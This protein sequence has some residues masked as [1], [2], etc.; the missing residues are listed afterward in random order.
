M[1]PGTR[2]L[3]L[4]CGLLLSAPAWAADPSDAD[5]ARATELFQNGALLYEEGNY[6]GAILAFQAAFDISREQALQY[7]LAN[8][9]E[10]LGRLREARDALNLYRAVAPAEE[11]ERLERRMANLEDRIRAEAQAPAPAPVQTTSPPPSSPPPSSPPPSRA[12]PAKWV[13]I[14]VGAGLGVAGGAVALVEASEAKGAIDDNDRDAYDQARLIH[15]VGLG[16]AGLGVGL[17]VVGLILPSER[18]VSVS[19]APLAGPGLSFTTHW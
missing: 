8:C 4:L 14:S 1:S 11:R 5:R 2:A 9:Y 6:A 10:R 3:T 12:N 19:L 13:L 17:G 7:N 15:G 18:P 16:V